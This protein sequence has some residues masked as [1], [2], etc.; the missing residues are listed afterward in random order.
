MENRLING[1]LCIFNSDSK[2]AFKCGKQKGFV[3]EHLW[4]L[5]QQGIIIPT[6]FEVHHLNFDR[7]DNNPSNLIVLSK[8]DHAKL[9]NWLNRV[10][11][12]KL[13]GENRMNSEKPK[14][15]VKK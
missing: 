9:H 10:P 3:Y 14:S 4:V 8:S 11:I 6:G 7:L 15:T 12:K 5:E 13:V 1:Y 2:H